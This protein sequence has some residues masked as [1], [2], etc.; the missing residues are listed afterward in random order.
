MRTDPCL[1]VFLVYTLNILSLV[2]PRVVDTG[3]GLCA[4]VHHTVFPDPSAGC[5]CCDLVGWGN[6]NKWPALA[7]VVVWKAWKGTTSVKISLGEKG[8]PLHESKV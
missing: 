1:C 6:S 8:E 7:Q 4:L 5:A 2:V 3:P